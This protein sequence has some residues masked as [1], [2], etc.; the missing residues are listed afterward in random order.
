MIFF[1]GSG[2]SL[3]SGLPSVIMIREHL[4]H[5]PGDSRIHALLDLLEE[6]DSKYLKFSAPYKAGPGS[7]KYT[8]QIYRTLTTYEDLFHLANI[9]AL[10]GCGLL[11]DATAESFS[12]LV[13]KRVRPFLESKT[14]IECRIELTKLASQATRLIEREIVSLLYSNN[15]IGL[16]LIKQVSSLDNVDRVEIITLN[17]DI[18]VEMLF[19]LN[20]IEY[21]DGFGLRDGDL[22]FFED[23]FPDDAK[24]SL[25]KLHGS[26]NWYRN[27]GAGIMRP[28]SILIDSASACA[29]S[30]RDLWISKDMVPSFLSGQGKVSLYNRGIFADM[31]Y[32]F[33]QALRRNDLIIMS[34]YGWGDVPINFHIQ[35]WLERSKSNRLVLLYQ[36]SDELIERSKELTE[37]YDYCV[38]DGRIICM[39]QWLANTSV[40]DIEYLLTP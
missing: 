14:K 4:R 22:Q 25:I 24:V 19:S 23:A 15:I 2:V 29:N 16:D 21:C 26:I 39:N 28:A 30:R 17:H 38:S 35:Y 5:A 18:L 3:A 34:G 6:I 40:K 37:I 20:N 33:Q 10:N 27:G 1:L 7:F 9:I 8:G 12:E 36:N 31:Q 32:R 11:N 13:C